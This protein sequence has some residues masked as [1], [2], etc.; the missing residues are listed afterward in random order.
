M[1]KP[2]LSLQRFLS[3]LIT[4]AGDSK[5]DGLGAFGT[6]GI[7]LG[8]SFADAYRASGSWQID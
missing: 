7:A 5:R 8:V 2:S 6:I 4:P 3:M 1:V